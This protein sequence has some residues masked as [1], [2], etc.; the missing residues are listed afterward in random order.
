MGCLVSGVP[1]V[2]AQPHRIHRHLPGTTPL[3]SPASPLDQPAHSS[4]RAIDDHSRVMGD[5][6]DY[7]EWKALAAEEWDNC[8]NQRYA[9]AVLESTPTAQTPPAPPALPESEASLEERDPEQFF[10]QRR[11][12]VALEMQSSAVV[13]SSEGPN[14]AELPGF[15]TPCPAVDHL[16]LKLNVD[17]DGDESAPS[18]F[19][20]D[21]TLRRLEEVIRI[22]WVV[23]QE[24]EQTA[25]EAQTQ[26]LQLKLLVRSLV[27]CFRRSTGTA[28]GTLGLALIQCPVPVGWPLLRRRPPGAPSGG[29]PPGS[30]GCPPLWWAPSATCGAGAGST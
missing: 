5:Y 18:P 17:E 25:I 29:W 2:T 1:F 7:F 26:L 6:A 30:G 3:L 14:A 23:L 11:R 10:A 20:E 24:L 16:E 13:E 4:G 19:R 9:P 27:R 21:S 12:R 22:Q 8:W 28:G 15:T